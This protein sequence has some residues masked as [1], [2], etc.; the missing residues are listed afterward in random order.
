MSTNASSEKPL[1]QLEKLL[2]EYL[3]DKAPY[4]IPENG[5]DA[6]VKFLPYII[7]ITMIPFALSLLAL[8]GASGFIGVFLGGAVFFAVVG[9]LQSS[10]LI[11]M[12]VIDAIAL[13]SLFKFEMKG[14]RLLYYSSLLT[15][16]GSLVSANF[17]A[18]I[19][20]G[21]IGLYILFQIKSKY[22]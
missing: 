14:W 1:E 2:Q 12:L 7:A 11:A 15:I 22:K 6:I 8:F 5:K 20:S 3:V 4:T 13:P 16:V 17:L 18:S 19:L 21:L 9:L 10:Y